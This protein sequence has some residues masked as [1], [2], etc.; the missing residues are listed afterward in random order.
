MPTNPKYQNYIN[1]WQRKTQIFIYITL[2][3]SCRCNKTETR[4]VC[5]KQALTHMDLTRAR[6][7]NQS[8]VIANTLLSSD[9]P[10]TNGSSW[11]TTVK[12]KCD[13]E[14]FFWEMTS[15]PGTIGSRRFKR[16]ILF[17]IVGNRLPS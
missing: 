16:S 8:Y 2:I 12:Q 4:N 7:R 6:V 13:T 9:D 17:R 11:V 3:A 15:C 14:N 1:Y 5:V 10:T